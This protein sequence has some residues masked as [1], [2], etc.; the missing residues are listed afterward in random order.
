MARTGRPTNDPKTGRVTIRLAPRDLEALE[1]VAQERGLGLSE[2]A[3]I[4]LREALGIPLLP[5]KGRRRP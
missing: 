4:V 3:R 1:A 2:A 5:K